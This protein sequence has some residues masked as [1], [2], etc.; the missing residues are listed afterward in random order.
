M[1]A[2]KNMYTHTKNVDLLKFNH[3]PTIP[4]RW[5][6]KYSAA[7]ISDTT[8]TTEFCISKYKPKHWDKDK[9]I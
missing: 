5:R 2:N 4:S 7:P 3:A 1:K 6:T 9:I 8:T